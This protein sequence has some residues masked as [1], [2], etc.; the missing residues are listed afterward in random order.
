MADANNASA[1]ES[2]VAQPSPF[3]KFVGPI[4]F[5]VV[6]GGCAGVASKKLTKAVAGLVGVTFIGLQV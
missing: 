6:M 4:S 3:S 1:E 2:A 5:G